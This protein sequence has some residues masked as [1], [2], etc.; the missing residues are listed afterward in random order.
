VQL[1][2][3]NNVPVKLG[4][5]VDYGLQASVSTFNFSARMVPSGTTTKAGRV[6]AGAVVTFTFH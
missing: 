1:L 3:K 6:T 4:T 5:D 2:D